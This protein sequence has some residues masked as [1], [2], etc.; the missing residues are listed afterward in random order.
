M[1][2]E[3]PAA[4]SV[5]PAGYGPL[6]D[7]AAALFEADPRVR[8]M[9]LHGAIARDAADAGSDLDID[10][11]VAD[12]DFDEFTSAWREWLGQIT[13]TVSAVPIPGAPGSFYALTPTCERIDVI[14]ERVSD[15][16]TSGLTRRIV[17]FDR[18]G[19]TARIPEIRD[20]APD[21]EVIRRLIQEILRQAANFPT[22]MVRKDWLLGVVA[23][24]QVHL[25]L[26]QL[27]AEANKPQPP[28]GPKQWSTKLSPEQRRLLE[29]L[30][31]PQATADSVLEARQAALSLFLREAPAIAREQQVAWPEELAAAVLEFL[32]REG[33]AVD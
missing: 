2:I 13:P 16:A 32:R 30:P 11:A 4:L 5:Y 1:T 7:R 23:V 22:V 31:V 26:Y 19:L 9:W 6:F 8:G 29:D 24:Q 27:F 12:E 17:V 28:T 33:L 3:R 25:T 20:P 15:V 18:D 14:S 10:I 21:P